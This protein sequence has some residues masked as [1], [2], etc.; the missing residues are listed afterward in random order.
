MFNVEARI[1]SRTVLFTREKKTDVN[2]NFRKIKRIDGLC[3]VPRKLTGYNFRIET[4]NN[5]MRNLSGTVESILDVRPKIYC[6]YL[7]FF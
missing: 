7:D 4:K 2:K 5:I 3:N 1:N 6:S